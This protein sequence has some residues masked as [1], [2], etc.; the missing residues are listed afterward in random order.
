MALGYV[1]DHDEGTVVV[2]SSSSTLKVN[3]KFTYHLHQLEL[4]LLGIQASKL[5]LG[6][7]ITGN[8]SGHIAD[9]KIVQST[10]E[11]KYTA[12]SQGMSGGGETP[13][14]WGNR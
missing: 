1:S 8:K 12:L 4:Q 3:W 5:I 14:S 11:K 9:L 13:I 7:R 2:S 6:I 10:K